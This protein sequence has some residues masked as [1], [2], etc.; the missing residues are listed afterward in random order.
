[1]RIPVSRLE[2]LVLAAVGLTAAWA[3]DKK[4]GA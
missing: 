3:V 4:L 2:I 1:V